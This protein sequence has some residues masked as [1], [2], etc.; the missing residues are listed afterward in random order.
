MNKVLV[1]MCAKHN[2]IPWTCDALPYAD[3]P[4][5]VVGMDVFHKVGKLSV[6]GLCASTGP[7]MSTCMAY[8]S[9][10]KAGQEIAGN[11]KGLF[12]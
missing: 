4:T 3:V 12:K 1:Q 2:G 11:V 8:E 10:Q 7:E 5:M 6:L 9:S